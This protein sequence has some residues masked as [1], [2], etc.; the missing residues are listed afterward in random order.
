MLAGLAGLGK[1]GRCKAGQYRRWN[2][3][4]VSVRG[5]RG[6]RTGPSWGT[7]SGNCLGG[8]TVGVWAGVAAH[9]GGAPRRA[10][11]GEPHR[12]KDIPIGGGGG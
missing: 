1:A 2:P 3:R 6:C 12:G 10:G 9:G 5:H 11:L 8:P 4:P 7:V